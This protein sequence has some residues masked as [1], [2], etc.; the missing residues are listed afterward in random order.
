[1][2]QRDSGEGGVLDVV[3]FHAATVDTEP[4]V[5]QD[6]DKGLWCSDNY[7]TPAGQFRLLLQLRFWSASLFFGLVR[8]DD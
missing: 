7:F 8:A 5:Q 4:A 1:M 6:K 3:Y 2:L